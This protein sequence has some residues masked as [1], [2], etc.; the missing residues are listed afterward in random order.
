MVHTSMGNATG[1][2]KDCFGI[3]SKVLAKV[4]ET[5]GDKRIFGWDDYPHGGV[6][7]MKKLK[8]YP[9]CLQDCKYEAYNR[10]KSSHTIEP[11]VSF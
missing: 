2:F 10:G 7:E 5:K 8:S 6:E 3:G 11:N 1:I 4:S 9:H